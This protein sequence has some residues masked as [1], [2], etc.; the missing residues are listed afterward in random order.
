MSSASQCRRCAVPLHWKKVLY[1]RQPFEDNHVDDTFLDCLTTNVAVRSLKLSELVRYSVCITHHLSFLGIFFVACVLI[2]QGKLPTHYLITFDVTMLP[3]GLALRQLFNA[4]AVS[5]LW[6]A[7]R[8]AVV[9]FGCLWILSP[10]LLTLTK[11][12]CDDSVFA[13]TTIFLLLH[14]A[15]HD[16]TYIYRSPEQVDITV[17]TSIALNAAMFA[18][19]LLASRLNTA[20]EVFAFLF[21]GI[22]VLALSPMVC[23]YIWRRSETLYVF[24]VTPAL[25]LL[26]TLLLRF[27]GN[28]AVYF[29]VAGT[30]FIMLVGPMWMI[31]FQKYKKYKQ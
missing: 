3:V 27:I 30:L 21:F 31:R 2:R 18:S 5:V 6:R 16:Y 8:G 17:H 23:R 7:V 26:T 1:C 24:G 22:E 4:G 25:F 29:Y 20:T 9:V 14:V 15:L 10:V 12:Y 13:T 28:I 11:T 19:V